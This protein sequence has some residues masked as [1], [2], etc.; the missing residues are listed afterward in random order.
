MMN[1]VHMSVRNLTLDGKRYVLVPQKQ[2]DA[3][4]RRTGRRSTRSS[5]SPKVMDGNYTIEHVRVSLA[6]KVSQQRK[7]AGLTQAE[8]AKRAGVRVETISRLE[9]GLHMPGVRRFEKIERVLKRS[10]KSRAA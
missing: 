5:G 4:E 2:W 7:A 10:G 8:L 1:E 3:I 6:N 9:S